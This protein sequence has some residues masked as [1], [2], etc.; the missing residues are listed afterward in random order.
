MQILYKLLV[1]KMENREDRYGLGL[2]R[3]EIKA[4]NNTIDKR[5][6]KKDSALKSFFEWID[7]FVISFVAVVIIFTFFLG[8]VKVDGESMMDT[9][10][11]EDQLVISSFMYNPKKGDIVIVSRNPENKVDKEFNQT[12]QP[13]VKRVIATE[14][15]TIEI[16]PDGKVLVNDIEQDEPYIKDYELNLGT[17]QEHLIS[18]QTVPEGRIFVMG[19]NRHNSHDSRKND[20][21]MIDKRYVLGKVLFRIF[22]FETVKS[23]I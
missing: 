11:D 12:R 22:P 19:D 5:K 15:D 14:G 18:K 10:I 2:E 8:K 21:W 1:R 20:I 3:S 6:D 23:F 7:S 9:L 13:I 16:T 4:I 17:P